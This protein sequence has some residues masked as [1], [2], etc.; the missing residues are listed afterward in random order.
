MANLEKPLADIKLTDEEK[1]GTGCWL[2]LHQVKFT[3][4]TGAPRSWEVCRRVSP[5]QQSEEDPN[6]PTIDAIDVIAIIK[7]K[8]EQATHIVLVVQYRPAMGTYTIEFPSGLIDPNETASEAALRELEEEVGFSTQ[9]GHPTK[10]VK[11][12]NLIAYEPG[13]TNSCSQVV[14][15]EITLEHEQL[16]GPGSVRTQKLDD[17]EW[18]LQV[19][20]LPL[21]GLLKALQELQ[22]SA[23]GHRK[24][25]LDSR[26]YAW[27]LGRELGY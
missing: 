18:S 26:L 11:V 1:L 12:S 17:D 15:V 6:G 3:D 21:K 24:L 20:I 25:V 5:V 13:M 23:G 27:V 9:L 16:F 7:N 8:Q 4:P 22:S 2:S 14:V 19:A 10:V